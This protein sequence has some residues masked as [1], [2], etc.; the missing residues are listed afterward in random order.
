MTAGHPAG[1]A[2]QTNIELCGTH[3]VNVKKLRIVADTY[4]QKSG[5]PAMLGA[6]GLPVEVKKLPV[7]D[8]IVGP[9]TVVERKSVRDLASSVFDGRLFD[10]CDRLRGN[11]RHPVLLMEGNVDEIEDVIE[12]PFVFYGAVSRVAL[13]FQIPVIPAPSAA[14]TVKLLISMCARQQVHSAVEGPFLKKIRK[15]GDLRRQQLSVLASLPGVG[16][17]LA[18]RMLERFGTPRGALESDLAELAK[19]EGLGSARAE[20]IKKVLDSRHRRQRRRGAGGQRTL[21]DP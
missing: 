11:Y 16:E 20:K 14:H 21:S 10:Q 6:V 15:S 18:G 3:P 5:I 17:K 8:Y 2:P 9:E 1:G 7:G 19:V 4:E 12:N 13:D